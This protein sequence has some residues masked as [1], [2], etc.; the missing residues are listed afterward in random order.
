M[1]LQPL[2]PASLICAPITEARAADFLAAIDEAGRVADAVEL[3]LDYLNEEELPR[4]LAALAARSNPSA[5]PLVFTYRPR[6]QGGRRDL[7]LG[8]RQAFWRTLPGAVVAA[9]A[10]ADFEWDL[11]ESLGDAPAPVPWEKVICSYHDFDGTPPDLAKIYER[12]AR[13]PAAVVKI[14]T[15][16]NRI[17]D[18]L[19]VFGLLDQGG[20]PKRVIALAM[21]APGLATR[22]LAPSRGALLTFGALRRGKES[23]GG[24]P[25]AAE[26]RDLYRVKRLSRAGEIYGVV[27]HPIGHSRSPAMHNAALAASDRDAVYIPFEVDDVAE[28]IRDFVRPA[29]RKLDW[30]VRGLSVTI[31]HK[32]GVVPHLD[33]IDETAARIGAV[34]TVVVEGDRLRGYNTDA[35]GAMKPLDE[36]L[37][38][39]GARVAVVGAGGSARAICYGLAERG[40]DVTVYARDPAKAERLAAE[41]GA[42]PAPLERLDG[43]AAVVINCTPIGMRGHSEGR[44]PLRPEQLRGVGLVYDLVYNPAET[45]LLASARRAGCDT[46][47]GLAMLVAQAAA[48]FRLWTGT[49]APAGLMWR[50]ASEAGTDEQGGVAEPPVGPT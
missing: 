40:A 9:L 26:L 11:V 46:L 19:P 14:A 20:S 3:R 7:S 13:T 12:L 22:I 10:Y 16:A 47:G 27:G 8:D 18:C 29:T 1:E 50:A 17:A 6:E 35:A 25:T 28:F 48:Q 33:E 4:V 41:F 44:S 38:I 5:K 39:R 24:Q 2:N 36:R 30:R 32:L 15:Q 21:G 34:N 42:R 43:R 31:P 49:E 45:A 37:D 23:A